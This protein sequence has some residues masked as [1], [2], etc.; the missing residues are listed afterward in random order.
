MS[1]HIVAC[2]LLY[3]HR[4]GVVLSKLVE[5]FFNMKE[6]I[7]SR[8]FDLGFSGNSE[9]V[10]MRALHLLEKCVNVTS[11][12][13]RNGEFTISPNQTVP[14]LFELNFY[15]NG[16]FHVFI[17]DAVIGMMSQQIPFVSVVCCSAFCCKSQRLGSAFTGF[18][19]PCFVSSL[20]HPVTAARVDDRVCSPT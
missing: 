14:A 11:S 18:P 15:S 20:Q 3:R 19:T 12:A 17:P 9:D 8:D 13:N 16:L 5:D 6:E 10:V 1:T 7:L 2:L 4:Q